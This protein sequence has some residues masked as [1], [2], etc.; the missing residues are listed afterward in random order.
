MKQIAVISGWHVHA[1]GYAQEVNASGLGKVC[2]VWDEVP[3]RGRE[4]AKELGAPFSASLSEIWEDGSIDGVLICAP[5]SL[6]AKIMV[7]AAQAGKH[8]FTEKVL[9]LSS[10]ECA[11][12]AKAVEENQVLFSISYPHRTLPQNL[13]AKELLDGGF[14][15]RPTLVRIR[16]AHNGSVGNWLPPHFY[17]REQ[18]GGGAMI[19]LGAHGMYLSRWLLGEPKSILSM[20]TNVTPVPVEDNAVSVI[21]FSQGAIAVNET[22]FVTPSSPFSLEIY[23]TEGSYLLRGDQSPQLNSPKIEGDASQW[24][25]AHLPKPLDSAIVNWLSAMDGKA[26]IQFPLKDAV[27]LTRLM[28]GAYASWR[29]GRKIEF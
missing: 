29:T 4:W 2:R 11:E 25:Q 27:A 10:D 19:D 22:G 14:L 5:T 23:G 18:C 15:G 12:I 28:E 21:E 3:E 1:K 24:I 9:A 20:F 7:E 26:E 17:D 16:N 8:I 6:H 13:L